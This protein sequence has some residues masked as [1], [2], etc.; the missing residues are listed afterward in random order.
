[1]LIKKPVLT[2]HNS[3]PFF[4]MMSGD[5]REEI[6]RARIR[7][8]EDAIESALTSIYLDDKVVAVRVLR[9]VQNE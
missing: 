1:M 2:L 5:R 3:E 6:L 9:G 7:E 8:L 4:P